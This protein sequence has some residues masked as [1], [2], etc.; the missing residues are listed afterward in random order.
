MPQVRVTFEE[1]IQDSHE[2]GSNDEHARGY[3]AKNLGAANTV[4]LTTAISR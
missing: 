4:A 2:Y 1:C 3:A